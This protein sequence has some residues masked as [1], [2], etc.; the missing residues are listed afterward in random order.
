MFK[1]AIEVGSS[2]TRPLLTG[3]VI[4]NNRKII[5]LINTLIILNK[6]GDALTSGQVADLFLISSDTNEVFNPIIKEMSRLKKKDIEKLEK[7]FGIKDD[8]VIKFHN[9][10]VQITSNV[11]N[12]LIIKHPYLDLAIIR[13]ESINKDT[14]NNFPIFNT[15]DKAIGTTI[16]NLGFA[17]PNYDTFSYDK[18][19]EKIIITNKI[20]NFP[21]FPLNGIITRNVVDS[22]GSI[23]MFET[24][25]PC[26]S[27]Q[28]GGPVLNI[29][30]EIVGLLIGNKTIV[31]HENP[32][33]IMNLGNA[34]SSSVIIDFLEKHNISYNKK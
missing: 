32:N 33:I 17:F 11:N 23:T 24:N 27:G 18:E 20:M 19:N 1:K 31:D 5:N 28:N 2:Y 26:L 12:L 25:I 7:K 30:G 21:L 8:T 13:F 3:K 29:N 14:F 10:I 9:I 34:I 22:N 15:K 6:D 16:C 4:Y